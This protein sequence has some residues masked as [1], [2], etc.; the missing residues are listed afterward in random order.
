MTTI[1]S[2]LRAGARRLIIPVALA[3]AVI[4]APA[5]AI[6]ANTGST[7]VAAAQSTSGST[8]AGPGPFYGGGNNQLWIQHELNGP[9]LGQVPHV[10]TSVHQSR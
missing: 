4:L 10:D 5:F 1:T 9:G 7:T 8:Y 2:A 6:L 3:S